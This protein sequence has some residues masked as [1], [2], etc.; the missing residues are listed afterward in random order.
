DVVGSR[1]AGA[2]R[3]A[4][5]DAFVRVR[6]DSPLID[7][8]LV[9]RGVAELKDHDL[10]TN[11]FPRTYPRGQSVEVVRSEV[12]LAAHKRMREREDL[13]HVTTFFYHNPEDSDIRS[14]TADAVY[15]PLSSAVAT[16][17]HQPLVHPHVAGP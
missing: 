3:G 17:D 9:E 6:V 1:L 4:G 10:A 12:F 11:V 7:P 2:L 14:S 8:R 13:E 16:D 5:L 15:G